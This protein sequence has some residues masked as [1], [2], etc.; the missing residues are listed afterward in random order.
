MT[1]ELRS[2]GARRG[3]GRVGA[4]VAVVAALALSGCLPV[5]PGTSPRTSNDD[6]IA[7]SD[8]VLSRLIPADGPGCSGAVA[9]DGELVWAGQAGLADV[10]TGVPIDTDTRFDIASVSKQ[11][12]G[13]TVLRLVESG[14]LEL[15]DVVDAHLDGM[16]SWADSVTI[17][18]LLHHTSGIPDYT[19]LLLDAGFSLDD[20]T[21]QQDALDVIAET[22]LEFEPGAEFSYSNSN[23]VLLASIVVAVTGEPF[24][25]VLARE[26]FGDA[27]L[28]LEPASTAADVALSY[29][30]GELSQPGWLQVGDGS[31]VGTPSEV[32][33]WGSVYADDSDTAVVAMTADA[34]DYGGG[35][36]YGAGIGIS[37][38]GD[39]F[40]S[41]G[42]AGFVTLFGVSADR[43]TV[44]V[45]TCN[46]TS[47]PVDA[48]GAGLREIWG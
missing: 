17:A 2:G 13:L 45:A 16:P 39:L 26:S 31:I 46:D 10:E 48:L 20:T 27:D 33:L 11:F 35:E 37:P 4:L 1:R 18:D 36:Q 29:E 21:T 40:H 12:T 34:A 44:L 30:D 47:L 7:Q 25:D 42:W 6:G 5:D 22:E 8:S 14:E 9:I 19:G 23:Y 38:E 3:G 28:R 41:G 15:D 24:A 32:A 43:T